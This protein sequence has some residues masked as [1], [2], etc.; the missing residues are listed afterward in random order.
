MG[1]RVD[2]FMR[3]DDDDRVDG[4]MSVEE[5]SEDKNTSE[6]QDYNTTNTAEAE[7]NASLDTEQAQSE[8]R[9]IPIYAC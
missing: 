4:D 6:T 8:S 2:I 3:K 7:N 9:P 1:L 5:Y